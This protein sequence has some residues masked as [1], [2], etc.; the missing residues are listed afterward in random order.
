M[1]EDEFYE[2]SLDSNESKV[3][4]S[5]DESVSEPE[6]GGIVAYNYKNTTS[7]SHLLN[8]LL[9][10]QSSNVSY[11]SLAHLPLS[12]AERKHNGGDLSLNPS[13]TSSAFTLKD[14]AAETTEKLL[15][16]QGTVNNLHVYDVFETQKEVNDY[17]QT[18]GKDT[19]NRSTSEDGE[20]LSS[21]R[22]TISECSSIA[23]QDY[24][25]NTELSEGTN[26]SDGCV[27]K[28]PV[29]DKQGS[30]S[31]IDELLFELYDRHNREG[32]YINLLLL[33]TLML[34]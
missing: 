29:L 4:H 18:S 5:A 24:S 16:E 3:F 14:Y 32:Y 9:S 8:R 27:S 22:H 23:S 20:V 6:D 21:R 11:S 28:R 7:H 1:D 26:L 33:L 13:Y 19:S 31:S 17:E 30:R 10:D 2:V 15:T 12:Q 25:I 34:L